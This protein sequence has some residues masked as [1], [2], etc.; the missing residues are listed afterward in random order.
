MIGWQTIKANTHRGHFI[1]V[2]AKPQ[3]NQEE[4]Q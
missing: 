2:V 4:G 3:D 1:T